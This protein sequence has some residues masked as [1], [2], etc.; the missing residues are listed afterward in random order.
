MEFLIWGGYALVPF[1]ISGLALA[2]IHYPS[3]R[4][5]GNV[6]VAE[7]SDG[8]YVPTIAMHV[9]QGVKSP[10]FLSTES[11]TLPT[12]LFPARVAPCLTETN[13]RTESDGDSKLLEPE[14]VRMA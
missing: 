4:P 1:E 3:Y 2:L 10:Q 6:M 5:G 13:R 8:F 11:L 9:K 12:D 14:C 7:R